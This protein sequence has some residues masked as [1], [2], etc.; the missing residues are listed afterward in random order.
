MYRIAWKKTRGLQ[1]EFDPVRKLKSKA[2]A[3]QSTVSGFTGYR[4]KVC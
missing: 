4:K 3:L 2:R 1:N